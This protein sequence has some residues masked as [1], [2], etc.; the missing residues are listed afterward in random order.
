MKT[1]VHARLRSCSRR[2]IVI[3]AI[4]CGYVLSRGI[5]KIGNTSHAA[6]PRE[7]LLD[8]VQREEPATR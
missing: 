3:T 5:A 6:D 4:T 2:T 7:H 8:R 1:E